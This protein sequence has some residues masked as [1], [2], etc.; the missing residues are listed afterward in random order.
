MSRIRFRTITLI[1]VVSYAALVASQWVI[2][3]NTTKSIGWPFCIYRAE[4]FEMSQIKMFNEHSEKDDANA[5]PSEDFP[6]PFSYFSA[7]NLLLDIASIFGAVAL[8]VV[9][10]EYVLRVKIG[11]KLVGK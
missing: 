11:H 1:F 6:E 3:Y 7:K 4:N 5:P 8:I 10:L 2:Q 9:I